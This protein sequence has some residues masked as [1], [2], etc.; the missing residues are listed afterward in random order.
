MCCGLCSY[1][2]REPSST[3]STR[4]SLCMYVYINIYMHAFHSCIKQSVS[5]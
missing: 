4:G 3:A 2:I 1:R 5:V